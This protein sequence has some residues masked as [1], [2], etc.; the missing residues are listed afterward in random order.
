MT[1]TPESGVGKRVDHLRSPKPGELVAP[2]PG[3]HTS[4]AGLFVTFEGVEGSGK[5]TQ[6]R[7]LAESLL[8]GGTQAVLLREPG[9]TPLA[10]EVRRI[11][12]HEAASMCPEAEVLLFLA[13]RAQNTAERIRPALAEGQVVVCDRYSDSTIAYQGYARGGDLAGI[14]AMITYATG[15]L[16]P[17]VTLLLDLGVEVG[18][19]RQTTRNRMELEPEAF[20]RRVRDGYLAEARRDP[21]RIRVLDASGTVEDIHRMVLDIV[22][23]LI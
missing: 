5:T 15:G 4:G 19:S 20:H 14:R 1:A 13:S 18:L 10:E 16:E 21:E 9:G 12:L 8:G 23:D 2:A 17:D 6:A 22:L 3:R 7:L 11:L